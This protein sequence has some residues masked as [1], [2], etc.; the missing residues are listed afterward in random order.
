MELRGWSDEVADFGPE[1]VINLLESKFQTI[2]II[3]S[4]TDRVTVCSGVPYRLPPLDAGTSIRLCDECRA[5]LYN[6][7]E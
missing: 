3:R 2:H 7:K 1:S 4:E 5:K 6:K